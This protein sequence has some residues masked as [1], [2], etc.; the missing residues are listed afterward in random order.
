VFFRD[1]GKEKLEFHEIVSKLRLHLSD[2]P[3]LEL[4]FDVNV[5]AP[6]PKQA[7]QADCYYYD[8][9]VYEYGGHHREYIEFLVNCDYDF[10]TTPAQG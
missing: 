3:P 6:I 8:M 10:Y 1:I 4:S 7:P 2:I 5:H 9:T